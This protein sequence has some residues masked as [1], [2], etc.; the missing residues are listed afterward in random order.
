MAS[1][2]R[3]SNSSEFVASQ[4]PGFGRAFFVVSRMRDAH[5]LDQIR[6]CLKRGELSAATREVYSWFEDYRL[7]L[8]LL[9]SRERAVRPALWHAIADL[10]ELAGDHRLPEQ[11]WQLLEQLRPE[12]LRH[13]TLP[14]LGIPIV[15]GADRLEALLATVDVP[16]D[17]LALVDH[18]SGSGPV[19]LLL[20]RLERD[21]LPGVGRVK[22]ARPFGNAGVARAWNSILQSFPTAAYALIANHDVK[23]APGVLAHVIKHVDH[24]QAQ[25]IPLLSRPAS[26]SAFVITPQVWN[27]IGLFDESFVPAYWEDTDYRDRLEAHPEIQRIEHGPWLERMDELNCDQ[28]ASLHDDKKLAVTNERTFALNRIWYFSR[29]RLQGDRRGAWIRALLQEGSGL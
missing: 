16:V 19:R 3:K 2:R 9:P 8:Q 18:S 6:R 10:A 11:L 24:T 4:L 5:R 13:H 26:F 14:L 7:E 27:R 28:S 21:G 25:W 15:N 23:F 22:V 17:T 29:R 1:A 20:D 12:R